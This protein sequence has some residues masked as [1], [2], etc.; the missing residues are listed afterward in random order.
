MKITKK[1]RKRTFAIHA[2]SRATPLK[3]KTPAISAKTKKINAQF[4]NIVRSF[5]FMFSD[6]VM[7]P[8][9]F[10]D[11]QEKICVFATHLKSQA[12]L[13]AQE[14]LFFHNFSINCARTNS[15]ASS[16]LNAGALRGSSI[17]KSPKYHL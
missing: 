7:L 14:L 17:M 10:Q 16:G 8:P 9:V 2:L 1:I 5:V 12:R 6:D 3:P 11:A 15:Y 4:N 13:A